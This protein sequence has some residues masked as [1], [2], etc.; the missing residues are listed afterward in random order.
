MRDP[1]FDLGDLL[2]C[3]GYN[4]IIGRVDKVEWSGKSGK[5]AYLL[6]REVPAECPHEPKNSFCNCSHKSLY[7]SEGGDTE[8]LHLVQCDNCDSERIGKECG[9]LYGGYFCSEEC[10]NAFSSHV[11]QKNKASSFKEEKEQATP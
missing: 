5:P 9:D 1:K 4:A 6:L 7:V 2:R 3:Y 8:G 10:L 11:L